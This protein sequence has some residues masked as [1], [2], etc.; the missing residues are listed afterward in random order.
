MRKSVGFFVLATLLVVAGFAPDAGAAVA[1]LTA[2]Y[3][4]TRD[5][6]NTN[7]I[8][9][10]PANVNTNTFGKVFTYTV[11]GNVY[12]QPLVMTNVTIPGKG[13][14]N[15]LIVA[16]ENDSVYAF[17]ADNFVNTPYWQVSFINVGAG[18]TVVTSG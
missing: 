2:Q 18:I 11:D 14:H 7:E 17:D 5:G 13:T 15:I 16:T 3:D 8:I 1:M 4:N 10:T 9:L 6:A 12:A